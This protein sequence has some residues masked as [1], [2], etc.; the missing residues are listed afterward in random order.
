M[1]IPGTSAAPWEEEEQ[2]PSYADRGN[3]NFSS[4]QAGRPG[5]GGY[6]LLGNT[7]IPGKGQSSGF[8]GWSVRWEPPRASCL[9]GREREAPC[10]VW[11]S[12]HTGPY[13]W[14][15]RPLA[16]PSSAHSHSAF[17][18]T[19]PG[20]LQSASSRS[21]FPKG[22]TQS[23][24]CSWLCKGEDRPVLSHCPTPA[25]HPSAGWHR[26]QGVPQWALPGPAKLGA[27]VWHESPAGMLLPTEA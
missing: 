12:S 17:T 13:L 10:G 18:A 9:A 24:C 2:S 14:P 11:V 4:L 1:E 5:Y 3:P 19:D 16:C 25:D 27:V 21:V 6:R 15:H 23:S 7:C 20:Y 26:W 22:S 8:G